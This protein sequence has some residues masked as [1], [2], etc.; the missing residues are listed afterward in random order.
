MWLIIAYAFFGVSLVLLV[1]IGTLFFNAMR[2]AFDALVNLMALD[3][4][5]HLEEK[6]GKYK[7]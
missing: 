6:D 3:Y 4:Q 5:Q 7:E 2:K 1:T